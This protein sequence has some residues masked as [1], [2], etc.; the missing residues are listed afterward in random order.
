MRITQVRI[1]NQ[2]FE[3]DEDVVRIISA[4][5]AYKYEIKL[6]GGN[7]DYGKRT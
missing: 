4:R 5:K 7:W 6:Y 1:H 2:A 3:W